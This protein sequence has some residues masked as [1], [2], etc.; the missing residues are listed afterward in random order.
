MALVTIK[1][2]TNST[3]AITDAAGKVL[4]VSPGGT[5]KTE[6]SEAE[7]NAIN[8]CTNLTMKGKFSNKSK[9]EPLDAPAVEDAEG[10]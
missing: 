4:T 3:L 6:L 7:F 1:N 10:E 5:E 9:N 8:A 2:E